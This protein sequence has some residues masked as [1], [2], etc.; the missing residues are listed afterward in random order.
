[1]QKPLIL[2]SDY[3]KPYQQNGKDV[4]PRQDYME[5]AEELNADI[6]G[7]DALSSTWYRQLRKIEKAI[8]LDFVE[9]LAVAKQS[10]Q[11][12]VILSASEKTAI[13]L[14][15]MLSLSKQTIPHVVIGH[16]LSS[17]AKS[18]LFKVWPL[19]QNF[20]HLI[21]LCRSQVNYAVKNL[22]IPETK[23]DFVYDKIDHHFFRPLKVETDDYILVVGQEQRDYKTLL[24]AV[25]GT[26]LKLIIV[27]SSPWST[28]P[29]TLKTNDNITILQNIPYQEL[30]TLYA[31]ARLVMVPLFDVNYAAGV[32]TVLEAMAMGKP[33]VVS[34][35]TGIADYVVHNETGLYVT[36][37]SV[38]E[39][40][41][42]ILS[43]WS[44][45]GA[46]RR[47]GANARQAV[48][49]AM[50]LTTYVNRVVQIARDVVAKG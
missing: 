11:Y 7:Y 15:A 23:V 43:L 20:S 14:A 10:S 27:A 32:N 1:M 33:L 13:P 8:K 36:A 16:K 40:R 41:D 34:Q 9:A 3:I 50:N 31:K 22:N 48:E 4:A 28:Y 49:Q 30:R 42:A 19:H 29:V 39:L 5:I 12:S 25:S 26:N 24:Q 35:I 6:L 44:N 2:V 17:Y 46:C 47:L 21:C 18:W 37:G 45:P 38:N